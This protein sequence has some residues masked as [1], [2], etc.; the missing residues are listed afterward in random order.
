MASFGSVKRV[1]PGIELLFA[2]ACRER[3]IVGDVIAAAHESV[4]RAQGLAFAFGKDEKTVIKILGLC[5]RDSPAYRVR[6]VELRLG[7]D[8]RG[9]KLRHAAH[10]SLCKAARATSAS[11]RCFEITGRRPSTA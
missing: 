2:V 4:N 11:L 1:H 3:R 10:I 6:H 7:R 5:A 8:K 9:R